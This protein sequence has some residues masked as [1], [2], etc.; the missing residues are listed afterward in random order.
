MSMQPNPYSSPQTPP[1]SPTPFSHDFPQPPGT[2]IFAPCP[3]CR[4]PYAKRVGWTLW[5]GAVGPRL[6][7]HV[8]CIHCRQAYNGKTGRLNDTAIMIY[9]AVSIVVGLLGAGVIL[10]APLLFS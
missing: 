5:G 9:V 7:T 2:E 8:R 4:C 1:H 6:F 3:Q 10:L